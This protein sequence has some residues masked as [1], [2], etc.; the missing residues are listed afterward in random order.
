MDNGQ[1]SSED[2]AAIGDM[3]E[4]WAAAAARRR[5]LKEIV[6]IAKGFIPHWKSVAGNPE[7]AVV[8]VVSVGRLHIL[9]YTSI[10]QI[11]KEYSCP[12]FASN[13]FRYR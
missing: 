1:S 5:D 13:V 8:T 3:V 4:S 11:E 12:S 6:K 9:H 2:D 10:K 7:D